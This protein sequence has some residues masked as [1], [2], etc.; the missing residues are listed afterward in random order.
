MLDGQRREFPGTGFS[1]C[2]ESATV[3]SLERAFEVWDAY[4]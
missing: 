2:P 1:Q 4:P 3:V